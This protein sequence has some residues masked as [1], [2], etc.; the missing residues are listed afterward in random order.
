MD[1]SNLMRNFLAGCGEKI[2]GKVEHIEILDVRKVEDK[3]LADPGVPRSRLRPDRQRALP[4]AAV[5]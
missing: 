4:T 2:N 1:A 5:G 3:T